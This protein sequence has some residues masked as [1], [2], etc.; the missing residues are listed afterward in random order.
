MKAN[1]NKADFITL[2]TPYTPSGEGVI[3][4]NKDDY[5]AEML[6]RTTGLPVWPSHEDRF[7]LERVARDMRQDYIASVFRRAQKAITDAIR[8]RRLTVKAARAMTRHPLRE[9]MNAV[10]RFFQRLAANEYRIERERREAYLAG[11]TDIY[12]VERRIRELERPP[13]HLSSR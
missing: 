5:S 9:S 12:D 1:C 3:P 8:A 2:V 10:A 4:G 13:R 11:A 7:A 6:Q